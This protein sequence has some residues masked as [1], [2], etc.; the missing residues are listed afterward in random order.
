MASRKKKKS[1]KSS[2]K[3]T[4]NASKVSAQASPP[5]ASASVSSPSSANSKHTPKV[6]GSVARD[7]SSDVDASTDADAS[8]VPE[9]GQDASST[10]EFKALSP[11]ARQRSLET[12]SRMPQDRYREQEKIELREREAKLEA[13]QREAVDA[14]AKAWEKVEAAQQKVDTAT[15][16]WALEEN[17]NKINRLEVLKQ[18]AED[19]LKDAKAH[20]EYTK[21]QCD[22][23]LPQ[24]QKQLEAIAEDLREA[25]RPV[26]APGECCFVV[27]LIWRSAVLLC[28]VFCLL[29]FCLILVCWLQGAYRS[30]QTVA[31][32]TRVVV[33]T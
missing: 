11:S 19:A 23:I 10:S 4:K 31:R 21:Q 5:A 28:A 25:R 33:A 6:F 12:T 18:R 22:S 13:R 3:K 27:C 17:E 15:E 1:K 16:K 8:A 32:S 30:M 9:F 20:Y 24:V 26:L 7:A 29:P 14:V 2:P